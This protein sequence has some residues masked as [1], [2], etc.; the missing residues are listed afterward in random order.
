[1]DP[2]AAAAIGPHNGRR[3]VRAIEV[4]ELTGEAFGSGL[5]DESSYWHGN[6]IV[7]G[8]RAPR[9][10]LVARLDERVTRMWEAGLVDEVR[11]LIP[12]GLD[13]GVTARRAIGYAQAMEQ[14]AGG[15]G[16]AEAIEQTAALTRKYARRQVSWF[17]RYPATTWLDY[18]DP[19]RLAQALSVID[20]NTRG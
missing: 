13:R 12:L 1:L 11:E 3:L 15:L 4:I 17:K 6:T 19:G 18:D 14:L 7:L 5:P 9:P 16:E 8:V 10:Q 20:R 2:E